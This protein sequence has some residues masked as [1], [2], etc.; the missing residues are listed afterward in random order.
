MKTTTLSIIGGDR[1]YIAAANQLCAAGVDVSVFGFD[2]TTPFNLNIHTCKTPE[3]ALTASQY[4]L[5]PLPCSNDGKTLNAPLYSGSIPLSALTEQL[6]ASKMVLGGKPDNTFK[7]LLW[8]KNIPFIDYLSRE[9]FAVLNAVPTAE[10]AIEIALHEMP[11]TLSGAKCLVI[12]FGRIAKVLCHRLA[13]MG[14]FVTASARK[15]ADLAWIQAYGY[16]GIHTKDLKE[17]LSRFQLIV[18]TVPHLILNEELLNKI[19]QNTLII[20]LAS[21]PGGV[22]FEYAKTLNLNV[23][24]ALALPGKVA[25]QSAGS[26]ICKTVLNIISE[27]EV[28]V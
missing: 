10:G 27:S 25:P 12:G 19:N 17:H 4:V 15:P 24:W 21:K 20:D 28:K 6:T 5:L 13:S 7:T 3:E 1:R 11:I 9:E 8:E 23:N 16:T 26:V 22:D 2:D 18:N 14:A